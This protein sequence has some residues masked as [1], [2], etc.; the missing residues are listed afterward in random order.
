MHARSALLI[1]AFALL[2]CSATPERSA[3]IPRQKLNGRN[4]AFA[5]DKG[6]CLS[7]HEIDG[8]EFP[9]NIGPALKNLQNRF[10]EKTQLKAQIWDATQFN[11][12]TSMPPFGRNQILRNDEIDAIVDYLWELK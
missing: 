8:G 1:L 11:P 2:A 4:L 7:C 9:G 12:E 6:N 10:T 3:A 5:R